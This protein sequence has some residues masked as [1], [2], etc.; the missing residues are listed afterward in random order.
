MSRNSVS[1]PDYGGCVKGV[2]DGRSNSFEDSTI[3][4]VFVISTWIIQGARPKIEEMAEELEKKKID[5]CG[6]QE[7]KTEGKFLEEDYKLVLKAVGPGLCNP[8]GP[9]CC[10]TI[11]SIG[12]DCENCSSE[13][14]ELGSEKLVPQSTY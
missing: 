10:S 5:V 6:L 8:I 1:T 4:H 2:S 12:P 7:T 14:G 9:H 11:K 3:Q 13:T